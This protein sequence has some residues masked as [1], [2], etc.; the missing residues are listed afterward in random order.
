[1]TAPSPDHRIEALL[2]AMTPAE[3]LGQLT[4]L[5]A[6]FAVT[7]PTVSGDYVA[8]VRAGACGSLLNL[9]GTD[10]VREMQRV[11]VEE[12]RLGIPLFFGFDVI[13]GHRTVFPSPLG[14]TAAFD[15]DLW[16]RTARAAAREAAGDGIDLVFAPMLDIARDP[17]WGRI[18]EGPGEDPF[19]G[20]RL[21][22]AKVAGL[23]GA[24]LGAADAVA[25]TAKHFVGYGAVQAGREY[26]SADISDR[27]LHEVHLPPFQAAVAS[28]VAAIMPAFQDLA[29]MP[30]TAHGPLLRGLL[31]ERW[32]FD[33]VLISDYGAVRELLAHGVAGDIAEAAALALNAG[34]DIDMMGDAYRLGL[35]VAIERGLVSPE[36]IDEAVRRVLRLKFRLGLFDDPYRRVHGTGGVLPELRALAR[37]AAQR[38]AVLLANRNA[39]LPIDPKLR[40]IAVIGPL[41]DNGRDLLGPWAGTGEGA[42]PVTLVAG[43]RA[44]LPR[45]DIVTA[46]GVAIDSN[47]DAGIELAVA[48]ARSADLV[49]LCLGES[50]ELSG[51]A[52][53]RGRPGLPGRQ[54]ALAEA[55]LALGKPVVA[56]LV[57]GRPLAIADLAARAEAV[58]MAWHPG[59]EGGNAIADILTGRAAP[60]GR[61]P[62]SW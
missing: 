31:R 52:A 39:V 2:G 9:W 61:L 20:A 46:S 17:R 58:L 45:T 16:R 19:V 24:D 60:T 32:G 54:A 1:M 3:K 23:Q 49:V 30:M 14:E 47:D 36:R 56:V 21:A 7:G 11:A 4:M 5:A 57:A 50:A 25:A 27:T 6:E 34:V 18:M 12:S 42:D 10:R 40:R 22:E 15:P 53:S 44:A 62:V 29:G 48:L 35:P 59:S 41:A 37:E 28:G 55:V 51:E 38:S 26:A 43:L 13:H 33:G 8:R